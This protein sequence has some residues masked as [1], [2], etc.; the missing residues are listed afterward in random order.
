MTPLA[1][2]LRSTASRLTL[3]IF[4]FG[5][6]GAALV[7][8]LVAVQVIKLVDEETRSA[9]TAEAESTG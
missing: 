4:G 9:I 6:V 3:A 2:S 8:G 7:L 5:A 1:R